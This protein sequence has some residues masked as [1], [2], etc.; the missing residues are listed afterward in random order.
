MKKTPALLDGPGHDHRVRNPENFRAGHEPKIQNNNFGSLS[1]WR[2]RYWPM[3]R[4]PNVPS[5]KLAAGIAKLPELLRGQGHTARRAGAFER[6]TE[7]P[8]CAATSSGRGLPKA[9]QWRYRGRC[10]KRRSALREPPLGRPSRADAH[11]CAG[12]SS[13]PG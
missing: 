6:R 4:R 1:A 5:S 7:S 8:Q 13:Y 9:E 11:R 3:I 2:S 10:Q 12:P